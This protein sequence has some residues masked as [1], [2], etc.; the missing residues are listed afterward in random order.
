VCSSD[1]FNAPTMRY[2]QFAR[3]FN[4]RFPGFPTDIHGL[5]TEVDAGGGKRYFVDCVR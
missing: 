1:L 5:V 2:L 4:Q 3:D